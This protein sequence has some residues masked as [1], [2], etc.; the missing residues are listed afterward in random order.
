[1]GVIKVTTRGGHR[2]WIDEH[3]AG[4]S[5]ASISVRCGSHTVRVGSQGTTQR[6]NVPCGGEVEAR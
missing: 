3:L 5:P 2:V 4:E 1:M 6:V